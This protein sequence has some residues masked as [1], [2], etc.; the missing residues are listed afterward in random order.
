LITVS[1]GIGFEWR[2]LSRQRM[3]CRAERPMT[4][5]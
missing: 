1:S 4:R 3:E 2:E 5:S